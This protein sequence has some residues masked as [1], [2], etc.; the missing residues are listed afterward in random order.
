MQLYKILES[1][2]VFSGIHL[3]PELNI[4]QD[5]HEHGK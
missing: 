3:G 2:T 1:I 4:N 5:A